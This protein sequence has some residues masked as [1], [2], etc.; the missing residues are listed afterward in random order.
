MTSRCTVFLIL[1]TSLGIPSAGQSPGA[2]IPAALRSLTSGPGGC[3]EAPVSKDIPLAQFS[4]VRFVRGYCVLEHG[5][6]TTAIVALD[7]DSVLYLLSS[8][9]AFRF[10]VTRHSP[11]A[12]DSSG[13]LAYAGVALELSGHI[14]GHAQ[15]LTDWKNVPDTVRSLLHLKKNQP[16]LVLTQGE[17]HVWDVFLTTVE[18]GYYGPYYVNH[19]AHFLNTGYLLFVRDTL[20]YHPGSG[21]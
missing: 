4:G 15:V 13:A 21:P 1:S 12:I 2:A 18:P 16:F 7:G 17:G 19:E 5:D 20:L 14:S 6:S 10:L 11:P 9:D 3:L 8:N